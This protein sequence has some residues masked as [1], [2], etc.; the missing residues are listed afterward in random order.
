MHALK[1]FAQKNILPDAKR[2]RHLAK[3]GKIAMRIGAKSIPDNSGLRL[4]FGIGRIL[5]DRQFPMLPEVDFLSSHGTKKQRSDIAIFTGC[6]T[7]YLIP[8]IGVAALDVLKKIDV[9][10]DV[11]ADQ[12][13][14]G[15]MAFGAGDRVGARA[16]ARAF[17]DAFKGYKAILSSCASCTTMLKEHLPE[18]L[19]E[20]KEIA[21]KVVDIHS[22]L[23][24][25]NIA[26]KL[27]IDERLLP[28]AYHTP[29]HFRF[30]AKEDAPLRLI[31]AI[32]GIRMAKLDDHCCGFGGSFA[33]ANPRI[34][35]AVGAKRSE[36]IKQTGAKTVVTSCSGCLLGIYDAVKSI[37]PAP[38]VVHPLA[39]LADALKKSGR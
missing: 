39:L 16:C 1:G 28:V 38:G 14:C 27:R 29:C 8:E 31:E 34:S 26:P 32:A 13:C 18:V 4:R 11:P 36:Q 2:M 15:L 30:G 12:A 23:L 10:V 19:P 33:L 25:Q 20:A 9:E 37:H 22:F 5:G 24:D 3:A 6:T 35:V 21:D 17:V 7:N